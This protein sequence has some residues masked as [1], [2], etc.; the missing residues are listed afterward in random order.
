ME[1][2]AG[3]SVCL[4]LLVALF[5]AIKTFALWRRSKGLPELLLTV[6]LVSATV[7]GYPLAIASTRVPPAELWPIHAGSHVLF[8]LGYACLLLFT[9]KVFR[10][11][12]LWATCLA[13]VTLSTLVVATVAQI[14][15][16]TGENPRDPLTL[17]GLTLLE[18][19]PVAVAYFWTT[20]ESLSYYRKLKLRLRLGLADGVVTNRVLLWGL[21]SLAAGAAVVINVAAML[22][23]SFLSP[24]IVFV[25]SLCGLVHASCLFFAFHPP[26]WYRA[27]LVRTSAVEGA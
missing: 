26:G 16:A 15:E 20:F 10:P 11:K 25:S 7:L 24:P 5:V 2:F 3:L 21:M 13:G 8:S 17:V 4:L 18:T 9:L 12:T 23:G 19:T 27:W 6:M 22:A 1:I 14:V